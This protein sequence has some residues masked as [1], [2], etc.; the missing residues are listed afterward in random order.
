MSKINNGPFCYSIEK[1]RAMVALFNNCDESFNQQFTIEE[2]A[3]LHEVYQKCQ[4]DIPPHRWSERQLS[5]ALKGKVP[6]FD[7]NGLPVYPK[8][9]RPKKNAE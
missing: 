4:W 5:A 8:L 1:L 7:D 6:M 9:G 3:K 2:L